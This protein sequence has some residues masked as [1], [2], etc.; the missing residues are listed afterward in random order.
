MAFMSFAF[1]Y[2]VIGLVLF[3]LVA[4]QVSSVIIA[5]YIFRDAQK[6]EMKAG[7]NGSGSLCLI[8]LVL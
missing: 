3:T 8:L 1:L 5:V 2:A 6:R 7:K 4:W